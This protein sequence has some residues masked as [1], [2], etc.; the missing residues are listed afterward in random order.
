MRCSPGRPHGARTKFNRWI[1]REAL[2]VA[3]AAAFVLTGA[4]SVAASAQQRTSL[5]TAVGFDEVTVVD[6][7]QGKLLSRQTYFNVAAAAR[8]SAMPFGGHLGGHMGQIREGTTVASAFEASDSGA[9]IIDHVNSSGGMDTL[10]MGPAATVER[11]R[12][13]AERFR[14]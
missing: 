13:V 9:R 8:R 4:T 5:P 3:G 2:A 1:G 14:R 6:A 11:C 10:C 12:P 7:E